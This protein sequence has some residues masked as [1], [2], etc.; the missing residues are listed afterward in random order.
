[1]FAHVSDMV[2]SKVEDIRSGYGYYLGWSLSNCSEVLTYRD[3]LLVYS[4]TVECERLQKCTSLSQTMNYV[5]FLIQ[6]GSNIMRTGA[7]S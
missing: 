1:M 3:R 4:L 5:G 2:I 6:V 7:L